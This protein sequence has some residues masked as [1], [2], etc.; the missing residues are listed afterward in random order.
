MADEIKTVVEGP[1]IMRG[2]DETSDEKLKLYAGMAADQILHYWLPGEVECVVILARPDAKV[3]A[4]AYG[5]GPGA[6]QR[7]ERLLHLLDEVW[8]QS[9]I[10]GPLRKGGKDQR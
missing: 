10:M 1:R 7:R 9:T 6:P 3:C 2:G 4:Y 8:A 5:T